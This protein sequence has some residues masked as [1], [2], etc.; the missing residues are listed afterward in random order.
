MSPQAN[1]L[2]RLSLSTLGAAS[3]PLVVKPGYARPARAPGVVHLG[4]GAFHRAHQAMV[5][6]T[7]LKQGDPRWSVLGVA[8]RSTQVADSLNAQDGLYSVQ[9][10]SLS[11]IQWHVV[12]AIWQTCVAALEPERVVQAIAAPSTRWLTLTV[13]EKGYTAELAALIARGLAARFNAG[14]AGLTLASCDNLSGNGDLLRTLCLD[15]AGDAGLCD[16]ISKKCAFPNSMVDRIVPAATPQCV[17]DAA[18]ALHVRDEAALATESFWAWVI[19]DNF[20][21]ADDAD[22]LRSAGVTV[23]PSVRPFEEAKLRMLNGSH[24]ALA[25]IGPVLGLPN[26]S[27]C[28]AQA[29]IH[30]YIHGLMTHEVMPNLQ[31]PGLDSYRDALLERFANPALQHSVHQIAKDCSQKI[32]PRWPPSIE[33]QLAKTGEVEYLAF[34]AAAWMRYCRGVNEQGVTYAISDPL[35]GLLQATALKH[36][37]DAAGTVKAL[38]AIPSIWGEALPADQ[39]WVSRVTFWLASID[40]QGLLPALQKLNRQVV[41]TL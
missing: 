24:T 23:V 12:G 29:D 25:C 11:S 5:F 39:R 10:S 28:I 38:L 21:D 13:T 33:A 40:E 27:D 4:L 22:D 16:W 2:S 19:E 18:T 15:A 3:S 17:E 8:M 34:A 37:G 6:D 9:V 36:Q 7:L 35:A 31:R 32:P 26:V 41:A 20:A 30:S 14:L 1:A